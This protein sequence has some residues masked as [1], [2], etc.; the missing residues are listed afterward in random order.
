MKE[1]KKLAEELI[2]DFIQMQPD[3]LYKTYSYRIQYEL[4]KNQAKYSA[5]VVKCAFKKD[6]KQYNYW[7]EVGIEIDKL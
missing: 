2:A 1:P 3:G 5:H 6:S 4:A 7:Q